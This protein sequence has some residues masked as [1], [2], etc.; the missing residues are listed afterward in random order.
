LPPP[1]FSNKAHCCSLSSPTDRSGASSSISWPLSLMGA[2]K[3]P[4]QCNG[5]H[6]SPR[7]GSPCHAKLAQKHLCAQCRQE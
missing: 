7:F 6:D 3:K 1:L 4:G 5:E 2:D